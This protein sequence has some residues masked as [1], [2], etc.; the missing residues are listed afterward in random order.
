MAG[1]PVTADQIISATSDVDFDTKFQDLEEE[2]TIIKTSIKQLLMDIRERLQ[3]YENPFVMACSGTS[4]K[5]NGSPGLSGARTSALEARE[6]ALDARQSRIEMLEAEV[7]EVSCTE[8][9]EGP[10]ALVPRAVNGDVKIFEAWMAELLRNGIPVPEQPGQVQKPERLRLSR[11]YH[12][13][14]W[15]DRAVKKFGHDRLLTMLESYR[16]MGY[17]TPV[18]V[19]EIREISRLM[20][21]SQDDGYVPE[22]CPEEFVS[23][24]YTL[25]RILEPD[26]TSV[27]RDMIEVMI[28]H[29]RQDWSPGLKVSH[30]ITDYIGPFIST[31]RTPGYKG[32]I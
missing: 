8:S 6:A 18:M 30:G 14:V 21:V 15:T 20:P 5:G 17:L 23:V 7:E 11:I 10:A 13:F 26:D 22:V 29:R 24:I 16:I 32:R 27:D 4:R 1:N 19:E 31:T 3:D 2:V 9:P 12:L 25:K 28:E